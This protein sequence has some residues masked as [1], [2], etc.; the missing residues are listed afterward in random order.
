[1]KIRINEAARKENN[2][3][4]NEGLL[5]RAAL[6]PQLPQPELFAEALK[7]TNTYNNHNDEY[8][9]LQAYAG[10]Y[11]KVTGS[12][13]KII[14][15]VDE[16]RGF[17]LVDV[18]LGQITEDALS[19]QIGTNEILKIKHPNRKI[20]KILQKLEKDLALDQLILNI[21]PDLL[22]YGEYVLKVDFGKPL[23]FKDELTT[24]KT[25]VKQTGKGIVAIRDVVEQGK[26][27]SL[28]QDA[29]Y[30]GYLAME[31]DGKIVK[32]P[33][34]YFV[35]FTLSGQR[36]RVKL[37]DQVPF[38]NRKNNAKIQDLLEKLPR[39]IRVG[40]SVIYPFI[41][42]FKELELLE[43]LIPASKISKLSNVNLVGMQ[44]P[45]KYD[46]EQGLHAA[47]RVEGIVNNKVGVDRKLG[48]VTVQSVLSL[49]GRTKVIPL[50][51]EKGSLEKLDFKND[52]ADDLT[53]SAK[54]VREIIMDSIGIPFELV[55]KSEGD[56]KGELLK[57]YAR[58]LRK[59]K[60][61][62]RSI[63][64][65]VKQ[66]CKIHMESLGE[67]FDETELEV[68]FLNKLIEIDNLDKLEHADVTVSLLGNVK[69]FFSDLTEDG[70]PYRD[71]IDLNHVADFIDQNLRTIGL[72]DA[73][74]TKNEGGPDIQLAKEPEDDGTDSDGAD[75]AD[76]D[77][78]P[79]NDDSLFGKGSKPNSDDGELFG[80]D[81]KSEVET[82]DKKDD[83]G[84]ND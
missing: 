42:K 28:T 50:F 60:N 78:N 33:T 52:E 53:G 21:T 35:K 48:E 58:Y 49:A 2:E 65:G 4:V 46:L 74:K 20:E 8:N 69:N 19:P 44:V 47:K 15:S 38:Y 11:T 51:G 67:E 72:S 70:S 27:V 54:D 68:E 64:E 56:N 71:S 6:H 34:S 37:E 59:L 23:Q 5:V 1:M 45:P 61:V 80:A 62:Q 25:V 57:R 32:Y 83:I 75:D 77:G 31:E 41:S 14:K 13:D 3:N 73:I 66:I 39:F 9:I 24:G 22:A 55:F 81:G 84:Q 76:T 17:Y 29:D 18:V 16:I 26:V 43:K 79:E 82:D 12:M 30:K 40:K 10:I 7:L 63:V 36:V